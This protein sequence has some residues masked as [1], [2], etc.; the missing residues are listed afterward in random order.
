MDDHDSDKRDPR[1]PKIKIIRFSGKHKTVFITSILLFLFLVS[2]IAFGLF[3]FVQV[4]IFKIVGV[5][6][7]SFGAVLGFLAMF[8]M[9]KIFIRI[10]LFALRI[11]CF[12]L[13][14]NSLAN[15]NGSSKLIGSLTRSLLHPS[16]PTRI[17]FTLIQ[18]VVDIYVVHI[19][20]E[21]MPEVSLSNLTEFL[22]VLVVFLL[23][24][25]FSARRRSIFWIRKR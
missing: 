18:F 16:Q 5:E 11:I 24:L 25:L 3:F 17:L 1:K 21:W 7:T 9:F 10:G 2:L 14:R 15:D 13:F 4:G 23:G 20:D 19:I 8:F 22:L 12:G 6:Y